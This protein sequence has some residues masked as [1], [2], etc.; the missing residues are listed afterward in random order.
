VLTTM[1]QK[2]FAVQQALELYGIFQNKAIFAA[3]RN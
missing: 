2:L 1:L 3:Q